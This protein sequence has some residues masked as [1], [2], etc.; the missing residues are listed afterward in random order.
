MVRGDTL[1]MTESYTHSSWSGFFFSFSIV[2]TQSPATFP[3]W[4]PLWRIQNI[5]T[6][7]TFLPPL[8]RDSL[9]GSK[10]DYLTVSH[11]KQEP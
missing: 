11:S 5:M 2:N 6:V 3:S 10:A 7:V 8:Q 1:G 9:A 4:S